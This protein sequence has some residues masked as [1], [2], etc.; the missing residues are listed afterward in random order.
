MRPAAPH[1]TIGSAL[2]AA[3]STSGLFQHGPSPECGP[4]RPHRRSAGGGTRRRSAQ[5]REAR[6]HRDRVHLEGEAASMSGSSRW[7]SMR[8]RSKSPEAQRVGEL[9]RRRAASRLAP[10]E[11]TPRPPAAMMGSGQHVV[12]RI[13]GEVRARLDD[14]LEHLV[15]GSRRL[16]HARDAR[17]AREARHRLGRDVGAGAHRGCCRRSAAA[18]PRPRSRRSG[19]RCPPASACCSRARS[20]ARRRRRPRFAPT[21][22][23]DRLRRRVGARAGDDRHAPAGADPRRPR[24]STARCSS[25]VKV[26]DSPVEPH[27]TR[28]VDAALDLRLD[29]RSERP[30]CRPG[31]RG[32]A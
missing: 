22:Q 20:A 23:A 9:R 1:T 8:E 2:R 25:W 19:W 5:H 3:G 29:Q 32:R 16:L 17:Q 6:L 13:D 11:I 28:P 4:R 31:R 7:F 10:T 30:A 27:G 26:A 21:R 18:R 12:A 24:G 15:P 14:H